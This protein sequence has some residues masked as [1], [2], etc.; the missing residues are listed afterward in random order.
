MS[1]ESKVPLYVSVKDAFRVSFVPEVFVRLAEFPNY[2][3]H[4]WPQLVP[5][6]ETVGFLKSALYMADMALDAAQ[7]VYEPVLDHDAYWPE[8]AVDQESLRLAVDLFHYVQPQLLLVLAG[9]AEAFDRE[10]IGGYGSVEVRPRTKREDTHF[11]TGLIFSDQF[12]EGADIRGVLG[13]SRVPD[14]YRSTGEF[15]NFVEL[16]WQEVKE[17]HSYPDFRRRSRGLYYYARSAT[18][19]LA[20]PIRASEADLLKLDLEV[21]DILVLR[22][23]IDDELLQTA[24]MMMHAE[25]MRI[26]L[27]D[28]AREVVQ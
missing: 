8:T 26:V 6:I 7:D 3:R 27:G 28:T 13:T 9:L 5:S 23:L 16:F 2:F 21:Q 12:S 10:E 1:D 17:L 22:E 24:V 4:V 11:A 18:K 15:P 19:F 20:N 14:I 25:C